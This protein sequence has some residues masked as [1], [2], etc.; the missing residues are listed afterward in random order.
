MAHEYE[1]SKETIRRYESGFAVDIY[2]ETRFIQSSRVVSWSETPSSYR[3][4]LSRSDFRR[5]ISRSKAPSPA[6]SGA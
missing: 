4:S 5:L 3:L 2:G 6:S 1:G